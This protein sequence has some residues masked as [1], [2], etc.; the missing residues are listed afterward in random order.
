MMKNR[1]PPMDIIPISTTKLLWIGK[2][3]TIQAGVFGI[4]LTTSKISFRFCLNYCLCLL[5]Y[6]LLKSLLAIPIFG[7]SILLLLLTPW[8]YL[9][10]PP[11]LILTFSLS[12]LFRPHL[13]PPF[14]EPCQKLHLGLSDVSACTLLPSPQNGLARS[15]ESDA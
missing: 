11:S 14:V 8:V 5:L 13:K 3:G 9:Y 10:R 4:A 6:I 7:V 12:L 2:P 15:T 1:E